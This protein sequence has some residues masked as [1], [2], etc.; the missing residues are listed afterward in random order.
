LGWFH[1]DVA[2]RRDLFNSFGDATS[3][4]ASALAGVGGGLSLA[5]SYAEGIAQPTFFDLYGFFPGN[6]VG[7]PL[8]RPESSRGFEGSLRF[9]RAAVE[10]SL[11]AYTQHLHDEIVDVFYPVS[12]T[13]NSP[14]VSRRSGIEAEFG[15]RIG[16]GARLTANYA[17][18]KATEP[19][20]LPDSELEERRRPAHSGSIAL[21]GSSGPWSYGASL[22][23]VGAHLDRAEFYPYPVVRLN[24]YW[25]AG[26][27]L[28]HAVSPG[29]EF[30]ARVSNLFDANYQDSA[31]YRTEGR[32][33]FGGI[34]LAGR[35]SSP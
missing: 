22:A 23:Y 34:R 31:G 19:G 24:S 8:L 16:S 2:V 17:Y 12:T 9:R 28:A 30:F 7:N 20:T 5:A 25:L 35:R 14:G 10:A 3:L 6:F 33:L 13:R 29:V 15:W 18:L 11:T 21:D 1:G 27:R 4:R 26:A 32:G